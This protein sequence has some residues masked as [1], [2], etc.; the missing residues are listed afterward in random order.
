MRNF[1]VE[2][3]ILSYKNFSEADRF[4]NIFTKEHGKLSV[5]GKGVR[6]V[7]S[8]RAPHLE[9]F[10]LSHIYLHET[11]SGNLIVTQAETIN[12]YES[13]KKDIQKTGLAFYACELTSRLTREYQEHPEVFERLLRFLNNLN[14][15]KLPD[16]TSEVR[17]Y[18]EIIKAFQEDI[19]KYLGFGTE[20][21]AE[22]REL[23]YYIEELLENKLKTP[24]FLEK[25]GKMTN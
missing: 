2:A 25:L 12:A 24:E 5:L 3:I 19:L 9:P 1:K 20:K 4:I 7:P 11:K 21:L 6:R 14:T 18:E 13:L 16:D 8:K 15:R 17:N 23:R 10:N 22:T